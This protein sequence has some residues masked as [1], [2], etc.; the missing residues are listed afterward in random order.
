MENTNTPP[1]NI[2]VQEPAAAPVLNISQT[3]PP[4]PRSKSKMILVLIILFIVL[5]FGSTAAIGM[6][7]FSDINNEK[8]LIPSPTPITNTDTSI[9]K[10]SDNKIYTNTDIGFEFL[11]PEG[12]INSATNSN[13]IYFTNTVS[14]PGKLFTV[15][16]NLNS[17]YTPITECKTYLKDVED[18]IKKS[19]ETCA[20]KTNKTTLGSRE[21]I[22]YSHY[23]TGNGNVA[24]GIQTT[25]QPYV[26]IETGNDAITLDKVI[27]TFKFTN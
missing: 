16:T 5:F 22:R 25:V 8:V 19:G 26:K 23:Q 6:K 24:H 17:A 10:P 7:V 11:M 20:E 27:S 2:P 15:Y 1:Q 21:A 4:S 14:G 12:Y 13:E 9:F 18:G 3:P